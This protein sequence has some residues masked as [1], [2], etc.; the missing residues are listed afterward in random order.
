MSLWRLGYKK[1]CLS[2]CLP[3]LTFLICLLAKLD[4]ACC[5]VVSGPLR[6]S[7]G[8]ENKVASSYHHLSEFVKESSA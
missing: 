6:T 1:D 2:S 5:H 8:Q 7:S 3:S 4:G